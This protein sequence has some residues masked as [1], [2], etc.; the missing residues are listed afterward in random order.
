MSN[1]WE[2]TNLLSNYLLVH[3]LIIIIA[4]FLIYICPFILF[5][6]FFKSHILL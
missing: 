3:I 5:K 1:I 6:L 2:S 4:D